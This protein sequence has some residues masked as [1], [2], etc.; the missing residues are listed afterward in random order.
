ML[1]YLININGDGYLIIQKFDIG[2]FLLMSLKDIT[3]DFKIII[4]III[5][6]TSG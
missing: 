6:K 5:T 1:S 2:F 3:I 4:I